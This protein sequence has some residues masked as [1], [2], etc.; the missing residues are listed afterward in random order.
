MAYMAGGV[1]GLEVWVGGWV[2]AKT[3]LCDDALTLGNWEDK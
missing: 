1:R 3:I 2:F